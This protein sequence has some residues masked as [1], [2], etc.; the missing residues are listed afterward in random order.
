MNYYKLLI[1]FLI[2]YF[3]TILQTSFFV[4]F[5]FSGILPNITIVLAILWN[6]FERDKKIF[7][8]GLFISAFAGFFLDIYSEGYLGVYTILLTASSVIIKKIVRKYV[9]IPFTEKS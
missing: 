4:H 2:I 6:I 9:R 8:S 1:L 3:L 5:G 7:S